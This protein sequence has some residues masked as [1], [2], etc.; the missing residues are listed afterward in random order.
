MKLKGGRSGKKTKM[1]KIKLPMDV[2]DKSQVPAF[3]EMLKGGPMMVVLVYADWCGHCTK[4][5]D[6]VWNP[7][8]NI[9][10]RKMNMASIHYDQLEN[11]SLK[12]SK[13]EGYPSL[14][15]SGPDKTPATFKNSDGTSTN[16]LPK[17]NDFTTMK[18]LVTSPVVDEVEG[19]GEDG[20]E[21][22]LPKLSSS[23]NTKNKPTNM[24]DSLESAVTT[25]PVNSSLSTSTSKNMNSPSEELPPLTNTNTSSNTNSSSNTNTSS[26]TNS[27]SKNSMNTMNVK[28]SMNT[29]TTS[30]NSMNSMNTTPTNSALTNTTL[31]NISEPPMMMEETT[32]P[33][34]SE[35]VVSL[36]NNS[37]LGNTSN[38]KNSS[39][40]P[41]PV[42]MMGGRLYRMLSYKKKKSKSKRTRK[43]K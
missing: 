16:A 19:D 11:T 33:T 40:G 35:D 7:L 2:R 42:A 41:A 26:N 25:K 34:I 30:K 28:K 18:N 39:I 36:T 23:L 15:V 17:A 20:E 37:G 10:D 24:S 14:L 9:K 27:S 31:T 21:E 5:K 22:E 32:P 8:K 6:N 12:N 38:I 29:N 13:I 3:E 43:H 4:Y 1:G